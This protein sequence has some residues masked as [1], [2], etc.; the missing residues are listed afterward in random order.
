MIKKTNLC[1]EYE[2][3]L[4]FLKRQTRCHQELHTLRY[5]VRHDT[6]IVFHL[7]TEMIDLLVNIHF[8]NATPLD[9]CILI[10]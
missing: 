3:T 10:E 4:Q 2:D 7:Y 8:F 1:S 5:D 9:Q 6:S